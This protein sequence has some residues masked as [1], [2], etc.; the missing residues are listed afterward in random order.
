MKLLDTINNFLFLFRK[1]EKND[2]Q[3]GNVLVVSNTGFG[4]TILSS[5]A[6]KSLRISF[7]NEKVFFLVNKKYLSLF[8]N[9]KYVDKIWKYSGGYLNLFYLVI[10]CRINRIHTIMLFHSN[11]PEDIFISLLS[12][13]KN[14]LKCSNNVDHKF[15]NLFLNEIT[16]QQKHNIEKKIDLV[17]Y[18]NPKFIDTSMSIADKYYTE[19]SVDYL[20]KQK[21]IIGIQLGA[22]D[23]YKVWP[24]ENFVKLAQY[25]VSKNY[26]LVFFGATKFETEMM[27]KVENNID[28]KN[29]CNLVCKTKINDLPFILQKLNLLITN[30]TGILHLAIAM[31]VKTLSLFGPTSNEE[32]GAY[33]DIGLHK[34]IQKNG[35][36][37]NNKPKKMRNQDGMKLISVNEVISK[38]KDLI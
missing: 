21:N 9:Y 13:A 22:Q 23:I 29:I 10:R 8:Y 28:I 2:Y 15:K 36:F 18:F 31:R 6:V 12:G 19:I 25:L 32:F 34:N 17:R 7:P 4:D 1:K 20:P 30:D 3:L 14:I 26:F 24:I 35:F 27:E 11:G 37:V 38:L 33:Q 5:P 16:L